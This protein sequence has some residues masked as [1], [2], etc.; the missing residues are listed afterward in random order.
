MI[1]ISR[2]EFFLTDY[3]YKIANFDSRMVESGFVAEGYFDHYNADA[4]EL[5]TVEQVIQRRNYLYHEEGTKRRYEFAFTPSMG[6]LGSPEPLLNDTE[7]KISFD[8][9]RPETSLIATSSITNDCD[10]IEIKD[11]HAVTEYISSPEIRDFFANIDVRPIVY[12]YESV[13]V[14]IKNIPKGETDIRLDN[15]RGGKNPSY[16]FLGLIPQKSLE[17]DFSRSSTS[18]RHN[19]LTDINLTLNGN[20]VNSF[21]ISIK[22]N[23]LIYPLYK[24][25]DSTNQLYNN[26][27]GSTLTINNFES[28]YMIAH[29]FEC[30]V[31][32]T[33]WIG[34]NL[35]LSRAPANDDP[36]CLVAWFVCNNTIT[37]DK[38]HSVEKLK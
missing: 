27:C 15:I 11:C 26:Q 34:V 2:N 37:V 18:F 3:I 38:F 13:D 19:Q 17:G 25:L 30:E 12:E 36:L 9:C 24:F 22:N 23:S 14:L 7:L 35:K 33:G 28:N 1:F 10:Y 20:S 31:S 5:L 6:F 4:S 8:R 16:L 29:K 21:P 32:N